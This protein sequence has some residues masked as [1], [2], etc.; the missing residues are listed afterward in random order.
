[1]KHNLISILMVLCILLVSSCTHTT[2]KQDVVIGGSQIHY[3][4]ECKLS[5][6]IS[7]I[8]F[9]PLE[10][11]DSVLVGNISKIKQR[12]GNLYILADGRLLKFAHDGKFER[13]MVGIGGGPL[14]ASAVADYDVYK[15]KLY[16]LSPGKILEIN[17]N[18]SD[19]RA[20]IVPQYVGW[21]RLRTTDKGI[22]LAANNPGDGGV[23]IMLLDYENGSIVSNLLN[24]GS[25]WELNQTIELN[26]IQSDIYMHQLGHSDNVILVDIEAVKVDTMH[27]SGFND[28]I[29]IEG[30]RKESRVSNSKQDFDS[31]ALFGICNSDSHYFWGGLKTSGMTF[32]LSDRDSRQTLAIPSD[33][34]IDDITFSENINNNQLIGMLSFNESD[35]EF[36]IST[37]YPEDI[38]GRTTDAPVKFRNEYA[39]ID[40]L[41]ADSNPLVVLIKFDSIRK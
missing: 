35:D 41:E 15:D 38:K 30:Y 40:S 14:E 17:E 1:M 12:N 8:Q 19:C 6:I 37:V 29:D 34:L 2:N 23:A 32:Y 11:N 13:N 7:Q 21:G 9:I 39:K 4:D 3:M 25:E 26:P 24:S 5:D 16:V 27:F 20:F 10:T 36:F 18:T 33:K 31:E 28:A 22:L